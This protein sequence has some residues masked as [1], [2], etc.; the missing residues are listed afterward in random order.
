M[1]K[2]TWVGN[3]AVFLFILTLFAAIFA[4]YQF[5]SVTIQGYANPR[6]VESFNTVLALSVFVS[7]SLGS[8]LFLV[9]SW[10]LERQYELFEKLQGVQTVE[11][12]QVVTPRAG[13]VPHS[14]PNTKSNKAMQKKT[15]SN[16]EIAKK[17][18]FMLDEQHELELQEILAEL[19]QQNSAK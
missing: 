5:P 17:D 1:K 16:T 4:G 7:G 2:I 6:T 19:D 13:A 15:E 18:D 8:L 11:A 12:P 14:P 3:F 9:L 10:I